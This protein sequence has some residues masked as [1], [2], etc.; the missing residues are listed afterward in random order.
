MND[1]ARSTGFGTVDCGNPT[2]PR[3]VAPLTVGRLPDLGEVVASPQDPFVG[4][5]A[6]R[7]P[8]QLGLSARQEALAD[9]RVT[10]APIRTLVPGVRE[11]VPASWATSR[12][13]AS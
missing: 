13:A 11:L 2:Q 3:R 9:P 4:G 5:R 12:N 10:I 8:E 6:C 1:A 7:A